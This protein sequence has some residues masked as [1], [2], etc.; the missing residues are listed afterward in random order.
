M[1][2]FVLCWG[3]QLLLHLVASCCIL[4][5]WAWIELMDCILDCFFLQYK[6]L[7]QTVELA[8][9]K[10]LL[11]DEGTDKNRGEAP[12]WSLY[13]RHVCRPSRSEPGYDT[14]WTGVGDTGHG[15]SEKVTHLHKYMHFSCFLLYFTR[16]SWQFS[17]LLK[18]KYSYSS[19]I[20]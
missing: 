12:C 10:P 14:S 2:Y 5:H 18:W 11:I 1:V 9:G 4:L 6:Q 16:D 3:Q 8:G 13:H 20:D 7:G 19:L 15:H 17:D